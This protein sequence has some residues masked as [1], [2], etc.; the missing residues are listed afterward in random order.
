[1]DLLLIN[2]P[3]MDFT[4]PPLA[5]PSIIGYIKEKSN[6]NIKEFDLNIEFFDRIF[7]YSILNEC[8]NRIK[9]IEKDSNKI[10][11]YNSLPRNIEASKEI[12]RSNTDF[13]DF[14]KYTFAINN[15]KLSVSILNKVLDG[16]IIDDNFNISFNGID[17][18]KSKED[19]DRCIEIFESNNNKFFYKI[20]KDIIVD[21][22][23]KECPKVIGLSNIYD[24]QTFFNI[25]ISKLI[26]EIDENIIIFSGGSSITELIYNI[27]EDK[28]IEIR[29]NYF[30]SFDY[31]IVYEGE[32]AVL[33]LLNFIYKKDSK[34][35]KFDI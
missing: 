31:F 13:Y 20:I 19:L 12:L 26:K 16:M 5:I 10:K 6:Y 30:K 1:M 27:K 28:H 9:V 33:N 29:E 8:I 18:L 7:S 15:F 23:K 2:L 3:T 34:R 11:I 4:Q 32:V 21:I 22:I 14:A 24:S 17:F 35:Q 25:Y